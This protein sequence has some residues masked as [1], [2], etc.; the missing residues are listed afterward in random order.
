MT[1]FSWSTLTFVAALGLVAALAVAP[2]GF[3]FST[4][5]TKDNAPPGDFA[6]VGCVACHGT[7]GKFKA[8]DNSGIT[9][10]I[11]DA[12]GAFLNG[13]YDPKG[14]YTLTIH[15]REEVATDGGATGHHAGFNLRASGGKLAGVAGQSQASTDGSQ[16][17]HV[18]ASRTS[19]NV[20]WTP[21]T[22][23]AV[24]F[25]LF[26]ND[27][28]GDGQPSTDDTP[29]EVFFGLTDTSGAVLGAAAVAGEVEYGI[30]LQQY[31]IGLI[32]LAGMVFI[33][34]AGFVYLKYGNRHNTDAKDR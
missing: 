28:D 2:T 4:G 21:P 15:L 11:R 32:G 8:V 14:T 29:H 19:W 5:I 18:D 24:G 34:V 20:T 1:S 10:S 30:S 9:Y 27:V 25:Q 16:A 6:K 23:G 3:G 12:T 22:T 7:V 31:W 26:V 17:T 33:M 13:P